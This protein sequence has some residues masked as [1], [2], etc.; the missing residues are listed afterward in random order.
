M[1]PRA[2]SLWAA[3]WL[4]LAALPAL[5]Q[6]R[7]VLGLSQSEVAITTTF[8]GSDLLIFGAIKREQPIPEDAPIQVIITVAGPREPATV[9]QKERRAG[10][11]LNTDSL[12]VPLAPSFYAVATSA[13]MEQ[14][15]AR[16][17]DLRYLI[18]ARRMIRS[19]GYA[20]PETAPFADALIRVRM[21]EGLYQKL[22]NAVAVDEQTLFRTRIA[23]PA[24][25]TAGNYNVRIFLTRS[26]RVVDLFQ[27]RIP[28]QKVGL[29]RWLY[30]LAH[31]HAA[32]YGLLSLTIAIAAGWL[33][34]TFFR[35]IKR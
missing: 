32:I 5:A 18:S 9:W 17:E 7:V 2:A 3:I 8:D 31:Q 13:P 25:L 19:V 24:N 15:L 1:M 12:E 30:E 27:T 10:I 14:A 33:A 21:R 6:E 23:L 20:N 26:G 11:W 22:E 4:C 16:I 34:A 29:E 35:W 28:V